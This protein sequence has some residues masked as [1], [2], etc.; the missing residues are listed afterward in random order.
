M[1]RAGGRLHTGRR[2]L[3]RAHQFHCGVWLYQL[4]SVLVLMAMLVLVLVQLLVASPSFAL[5]VH[6]LVNQLLI[7]DA[8][9][10]LRWQCVEGGHI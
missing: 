1:R 10:L 5:A 9:L 7:L 8:V 6:P 2:R 3:H 4:L